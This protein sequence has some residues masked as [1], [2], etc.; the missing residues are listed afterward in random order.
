M[1]NFCRNLSKMQKKSLFFLVNMILILSLSYVFL[2]CFV[3]VNSKDDI[4]GQP[5]I[6]IIL[7]CLTLESGPSQTL[8]NR[9]DKALLYLEEFPDLSIIVSGGQGSNEPWTEALAMSQYLEEHGVPS[10]QIYQEGQSSNTHQNLTFS[11]ELIEKEGLSGDVI[12]V[13]SGFHLGRA[14]FLWKR[15]GGDNENLSTLAAPVTD[16][17]KR[18]YNHI[19]EPMAVVKSFLFDTGLATKT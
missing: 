8:A 2:L 17:N 13:S 12:I 14:K 3:L 10:S 15:V 16:F 9:L 19:R 11:M 4:K 18:L 7:G 6:M 5:E 1:K